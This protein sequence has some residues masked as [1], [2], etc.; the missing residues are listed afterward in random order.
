MR[1]LPLAV[2]LLALA[3]LAPASSS[4]L[5][6]AD[7]LAVLSRGINITG[8]F[9]FP[10]SRDPAVLRDWLS[11]TAMRDLKR[12]GFSFV[13]LA[14]DPALFDAPAALDRVKMRR[15]LIDQV[16]RLQQFGLAVMIS[17]HPVG[18]NVDQSQTD[19]LKLAAFWRDM[20]PAL[21]GLPANLTFPEVL[22]EPVFHDDPTAWWRLQDSLRASIRSA[23]PEQT[24]VLTGHDWGSVAGLLALTPSSD[25]NVVYSFH[26]YDPSELTS[27]AAWHQ[28]LD[29]SAMALLPFPET[30][31]AQCQPALDSTRDRETSGVIR[32]YCATGWDESR[33]SA[34]L[35]A[36][37]SWAAQHHVALLAG[38][39]GA[40][41]R[42]NPSARL[43][44]LKVVRS[45]C[46]ANG[47]GWALWG[48]DDVMGFD[49]RRPPE[50]E[51]RLDRSV[52]EALGLSLM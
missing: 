35:L 40:S 52:L 50:N 43:A 32:F 22:N 11:D 8:W 41:A 36:A 9:R 38:E 27:L 7:R 12:V 23:L 26:F 21:H 39:F 4:A 10:A 19:Q 24:I 13:R 2:C 44:W 17:P 1:A 6:P 37:A 29:Q 46:A 14:V 3:L 33:V 31:P 47:I 15:V 16:R 30:N 34:R 20:A 28:G 42:V 51:P 25:A 18:W 45:T 48:Y 5:P 49:V